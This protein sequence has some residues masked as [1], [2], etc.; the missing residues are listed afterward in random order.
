MG[1]IHVGTSS[2]ADP[3][4]V[5]EWYP[6][7]LPAPERLAFYAERFEAVEVNSTFYAVPAQRT[8]ARW[9]EQTPADFSFDVKL[10]RLLSRHSADERSLPADLRRRARTNERGRVLL[11]PRLEA[12]LADR[13][14]EAVAPLG[15]KLATFLLQLSPAFEPRRNRLGELA[16]L[17]ERL[18]ATAPVAIELRNRFWLAEERIED[19]LSWFEEH[20]AAFVCIDGPHGSRSP[21]VMPQLDAATRPDVAYLRAHGRNLEGYLRGRTVAERFAYRYEDSEL[22]ELGERARH[23]A[24]EV[25]NVRMMFN[26]NRGADAPESAARMRELLGRQA[27]APVQAR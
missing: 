22:E 25:P 11:G 9:A 2:W 20:G 17:V 14:A 4:F 23:L 24:E 18:S 1:R 16:A 19:T 8:V 5:E 26:N 6:E 10:H 12:A 13:I 3:G 15:G 7:G 27:A 21:T